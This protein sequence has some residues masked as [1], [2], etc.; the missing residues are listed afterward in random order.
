MLTRV[1]VYESRVSVNGWYSAVSVLNIDDSVSFSVGVRPLFIRL[2]YALVLV[3]VLVLVTVLA[4]AA[5]AAAAPPRKPTYT[6]NPLTA[7]WR[8]WEG[9]SCRPRVTAA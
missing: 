1:L 7:A 3:L 8:W 9:A 2:V 4:L 6:S 5:A